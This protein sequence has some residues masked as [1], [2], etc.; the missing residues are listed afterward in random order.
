VACS[1]ENET[2]VADEFGAGTVAENSVWEITT[3]SSSTTSTVVSPFDSTYRYCL[4]DLYRTEGRNF[5]ALSAFQPVGDEWMTSEQETVTNIYGWT[6]VAVLV[7][8]I[9]KF[10]WGWL[11]DLQG[12]FRSTYK[13]SAGTSLHHIVLRYSHQRW[14]FVFMTALWQGSGNQL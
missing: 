3:E 13:V 12:F 14:F 11:E 1:T 7:I 2:T 8:V 5:P 9:L 10:I 4:Q 6:S